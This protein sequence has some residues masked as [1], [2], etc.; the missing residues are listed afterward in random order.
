MSREG[1]QGRG[2]MA[3]IQCWLRQFQEA[4]VVGS[5][6]QPIGLNA[7]CRPWGRHGAGLTMLLTG[8][9]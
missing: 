3:V 8:A 7:I 6:C 1:C 5:H 2:E 4:L 9:H